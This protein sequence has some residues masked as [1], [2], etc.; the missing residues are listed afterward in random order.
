[1]VLPFNEATKQRVLCWGVAFATLLISFTIPLPIISSLKDVIQE[2]IADLDSAFFPSIRRAPL[3]PIIVW[4][5]SKVINPLHILALL[6]TL[7]I[8]VKRSI[9]L[10]VTS[11]LLLWAPTA[12]CTLYYACEESWF[13][14]SPPVIFTEM[15]ISSMF[16]YLLRKRGDFLWWL[17]MGLIYGL[18]PVIITLTPILLILL[19]PIVGLWL[20]SVPPLHNFIHFFPFMIILFGII[21][22]VL[23]I[24]EAAHQH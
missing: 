8:L 9:M 19:F 6:Y 10:T 15:A 2:E 16:L 12:I 18:L 4:E 13:G 23:R 17:P 3:L 22:G 7:P 20:F 5:Y 14:S 11:S 1:M 24:K 21:I